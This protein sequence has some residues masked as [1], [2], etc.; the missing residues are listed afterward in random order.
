V[1]KRKTEKI[2]TFS[3]SFEVRTEKPPRLVEILNGNSR[4]AVSKARLGAP[5]VPREPLGDT[6]LRQRR[7]TFG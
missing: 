3:R 2:P 7:L 5:T 6:Q 4:T 1:G